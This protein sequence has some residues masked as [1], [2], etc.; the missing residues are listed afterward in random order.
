MTANTPE[1]KLA[2]AQQYTTIALRVRN[3]LIAVA[4][5]ALTVAIFL[6]SHSQN[7][8]ASLSKMASEAT[9]FNVATSNGKPTLLE[10]YAN[11]C[12][13]CQSMVPQMAALQKQYAE[14]LNFV[15]LNVDNTKWL[16]EITYYRVDGI[17]HFVFLDRQGKAIAQTIGE[18]PSSIMEENIKALIAG[19]PLPHAQS[20]GQISPWETPIN[21]TSKR[22]TDPR[23]HGSFAQSQS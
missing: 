2:S 12:T 18:Q 15:M 9:P 6:G 3:F 14:P 10:F 7:P 21:S 1:S 4:A 19:L 8:S 20:T 13:T 17:P 22:A 11:W 16:P 5:I 23:S